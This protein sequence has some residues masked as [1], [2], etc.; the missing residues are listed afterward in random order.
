ME[1]CMVEVRVTKVQ[2]NANASALLQ[3]PRQ[4]IQTTAIEGTNNFLPRSI[5]LDVPL[6]NGRS[7]TRGFFLLTSIPPCVRVQRNKGC[8]LLLSI[9]MVMRRNGFDR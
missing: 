4:Q 7:P 9:L 2:K 6:F 8:K 5:R 3:T 1:A